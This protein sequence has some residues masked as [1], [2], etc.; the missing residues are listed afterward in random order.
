MTIQN[1]LTDKRRYTIEIQLRLRRG[2]K[3]RCM[4]H[5]RIQNLKR[6]REKNKIKKKKKRRPE[7]DVKVEERKRE[8]GI[9]CKFIPVTV[10]DIW[11]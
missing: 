1:I 10:I 11:A 7:E 8:N 6:K 2:V 9:T 4:E 5:G 3:Q